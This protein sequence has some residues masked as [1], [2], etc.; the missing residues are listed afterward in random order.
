MP[1]YHGDDSDAAVLAR[2]THVLTYHDCIMARDGIPF[3]ALCT[4]GHDRGQ[5]SRTV[6]CSHCACEDF[7]W[8][9]TYTLDYHLYRWTRLFE[10]SHG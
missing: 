3:C 8:A 10:G 6:D 5:H 2:T 7:E 9:G 4:C 1:R